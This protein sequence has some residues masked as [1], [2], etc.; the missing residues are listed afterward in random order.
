MNYGQISD[1][2][3]ADV[4]NAP[5]DLFF[6][7]RY[8]RENFTGLVDDFAIFFAIKE[9]SKN[10]TRGMSL[11]DGPTTRTRIG[12]QWTCAYGKTHYNPALDPTRTPN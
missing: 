10:G 4:G 5:T 7:I 8:P 11:T 12:S 3:F 2:R 6:D 1:T 9:N